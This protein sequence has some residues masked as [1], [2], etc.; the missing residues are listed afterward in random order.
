[1]TARY[2][3]TALCF[4]G[5]FVGVIGAVQDRPNKVFEGALLQAIGVFGDL[6]LAQG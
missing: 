4:A 2:L 5:C 6:V 1:M 3:C